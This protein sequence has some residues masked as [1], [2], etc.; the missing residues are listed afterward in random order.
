LERLKKIDE[1][2]LK[3][4]LREKTIAEEN[5]RRLE[6]RVGQDFALHQNFVKINNVTELENKAFVADTASLNSEK[7]KG[8]FHLRINHG[9][10]MS[11][12]IEMYANDNVAFLLHKGRNFLYKLEKEEEK[13]KVEMAQQQEEDRKRRIEED[14]RRQQ[15]LERQLLEI[16]REKDAIAYAAFEMPVIPVQEVPEEGD[17][18]RREHKGKEP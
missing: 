6:N 5:L 15:E 9:L 10:N 13:M 11:K 3:H 18:T 12:K 2:G 16:Q 4:R 1:R 8:R 14:K 7:L 17:E